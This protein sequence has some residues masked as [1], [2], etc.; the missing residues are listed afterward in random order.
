V[1]RVLGKRRVTPACMAEIRGRR[2]P[3]VCA[4]LQSPYCSAVVAICPDGEGAR[5][6]A[7]VLRAY[8]EAPRDDRTRFAPTT[9]TETQAEQHFFVRREARERVIR[10]QQQRVAVRRNLLSGHG[11]TGYPHPFRVDNEEFP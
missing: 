1:E 3:S 10:F 9:D 8:A 7:Q 4:T 2:S 5:S 6:V 11:K